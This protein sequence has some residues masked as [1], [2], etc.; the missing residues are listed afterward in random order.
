MV[1]DAL[2]DQN[3]IVAEGPFEKVAIGF[4]K[5]LMR[6]K[7]GREAGEINQQKWEEMNSVSKQSILFQLN[8]T[9]S[10]SSFSSL[11]VEM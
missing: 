6:E 9:W 4:Y 3:W 5:F 2:C 10:S 8:R 7:S 1:M 11:C